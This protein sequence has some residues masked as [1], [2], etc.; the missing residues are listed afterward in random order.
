MLY[1]VNNRGRIVGG[2]VD[3]SGNIQQFLLD[4]GVYT[5][6]DYPGAAFTVP[7]DINDR[8]QV[9]GTYLDTAGT[10]NGFVLDDGVYTKID[11]SA[12]PSGQ[13]LGLNDRGQIVG[14]YQDA[15]GKVR[16]LLRDAKGGFTTFF[17]PQAVSETAALD[18][19][20]RRQIV[21]VFR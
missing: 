15:G 17:A 18:I 16:G 1:S 13:L 2:Y 12:F 21:G 8:D 20:D 3:A 11:I 6:I 19:N 4:N 7:F 5:P 9:V 14:G 10:P